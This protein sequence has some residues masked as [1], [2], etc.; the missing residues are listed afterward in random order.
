MSLLSEANRQQILYE[1]KLG[2]APTEESIRKGTESIYLRKFRTQMFSLLGTPQYVESRPDALFSD[3]YYM[4]LNKYKAQK[5][6]KTG[7]LLTEIQAST[8]AE[9][10]FQKQMRLAGGEDFPIDRL[11]TNARDKATYIQ[12]SQKAYSRIYKDFAGL[13][14]ELERVDPSLVGLMTADLPRDYDIQISKFLNDPNATL[15]GGTVLNSQLK[16]P[17]MVEDELTKSRLWGAYTSFKDQLNVAAKKAGYASYLSVPELKDQ[18]REYASTLGGVS[19][20]WF[21]DYAGGSAAKDNAWLQS[22]GIKKLTTD[23]AFMKQYGNT[24]FWQHAKAFIEYRDSFAKVRADAPSGYKTKVEESWQAYL[25]ESLTLWDP[26]LQKMI[27][28][29]YSND[30]LNT[31]EPS[32]G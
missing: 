25:E 32:N 23:K 7:K 30:K 4:L 28:R 11:F 2:P 6:P 18:L 21:A 14:K 13:A 3:Y 16:T 24:Q 29:Y 1:M 5:D 12:P 8:L 22:Y 17:Q 15:P 10:E 31:K 9:D 20:A 27:T 26:T 19:D